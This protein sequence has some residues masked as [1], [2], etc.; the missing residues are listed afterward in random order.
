MEVYEAY[1]KSVITEREKESIRRYLGFQ[2]TGINI[3]ADLTPERYLQLEKSG[4]LLPKNGEEVKQLIEEFVNVYSAM[5]KNKENYRGGKLVRGTSVAEVEKLGSE[6][7]QL[8]STSTDEQIAK[9]FTEYQNG[10]LLHL[11]VRNGVPF[12]NAEEYREQDSESEQEIILAPFCTVTGIEKE[13]KIEG[14]Q[15]Y[16]I[17]VGAPRLQSKSPEELNELMEEVVQGFSQNIDNIKER[18]NFSKVREFREKLQALLKGMCRQK[19]LEFDKAKQV[20]KQDKVRQAEE[21][22]RKEQE[23]AKM[24]EEEA[25]RRAEQTKKD[26]VA[27][28]IFKAEKNPENSQ[29]LSFRNHESLS[30]VA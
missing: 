10:A 20:I 4:W 16:S 28:I 22:K 24:R 12:L 3:L 17:A 18:Q 23:E 6:F 14:F 9:R 13:H 21:A 19:E 15:N 29:N 11:Y 26:K 25:K 8:V 1:Q 30:R 7:N 27:E 5:Y 2:H